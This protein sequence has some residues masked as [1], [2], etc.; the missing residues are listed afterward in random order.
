MHSGPFPAIFLFW[1]LLWLTASFLEEKH[2]Y[3]IGQGC[4]TLA[5]GAGLETAKGPVRGASAKESR[6]LGGPPRATPSPTTHTSEVKNNP[7]A[8]LNEIAFD[9]PA[10]GPY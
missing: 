5:C 10:V 9:I 8:A 6:A 3:A 2:Y 7:E 1:T 4:Q